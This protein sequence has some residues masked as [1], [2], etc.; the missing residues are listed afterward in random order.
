MFI[1]DYFTPCYNGGAPWQVFIFIRQVL[2]VQLPPSFFTL[3][4]TDSCTV[5]TLPI[6]STHMLHLA[7]LLW[8]TMWT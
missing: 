6:A 4:R 3:F 7:P 5:A 1:L 8:L 2:D